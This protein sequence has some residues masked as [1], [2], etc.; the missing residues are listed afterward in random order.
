MVICSCPHK[1]LETAVHRIKGLEV[2][3]D[4]LL[5]HGVR[6]GIG[7]LFPAGDRDVG[8]KIGELFHAD[9]VQHS[10]YIRIGMRN[11]RILGHIIRR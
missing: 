5:R 4:F 7:A 10:L 8:I 9:P 11:V 3:P 2:I 6:K 1:H